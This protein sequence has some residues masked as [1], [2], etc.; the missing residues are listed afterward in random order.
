M[1]HVYC[2]TFGHDLVVVKEV[3]A[4]VKEF[5]CR[6]CG[7]EFTTASN[8]KITSLS[9]THRDINRLLNEMYLKRKRRLV[10]HRP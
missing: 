2:S 7:R 8:G 9:N 4:H 5:R 6:K 10:K 3:T 1:K